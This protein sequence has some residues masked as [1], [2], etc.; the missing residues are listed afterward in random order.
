MTSYHSGVDGQVRKYCGSQVPAE[1]FLSFEQVVQINMVTD[2][3]TTGAGFTLRYRLAT[4]SRTLTLANGQLY[5]CP[6]C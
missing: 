2:A 5:R 3:S 4:C 6:T 1:N